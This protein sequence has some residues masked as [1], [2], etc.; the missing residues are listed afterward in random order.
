MPLTVFSKYEMY[1]LIKELRP[2]IGQIC[3]KYFSVSTSQ[4]YKHVI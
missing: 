2:S 1:I 4:V 3:K